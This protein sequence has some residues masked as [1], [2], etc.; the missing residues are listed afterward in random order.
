MRSS[1]SSTLPQSIQAFVKQYC[2]R[3]FVCGVFLGLLALAAAGAS[4]ERS[5]SAPPVA[6]SGMANAH[7]GGGNLVPVW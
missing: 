5:H 2:Y 1:D 3:P 4:S 7:S 6:I